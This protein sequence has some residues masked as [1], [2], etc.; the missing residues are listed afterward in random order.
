MAD[1]G[2]RLSRKRLHGGPLRTAINSSTYGN[3]VDVLKTKAHEDIESLEK[4]T[5]RLWQACGNF[6]ADKQ[7]D[8]PRSSAGAKHGA[9]LEAQ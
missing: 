6:W 5:Q 4:G 2:E 9:P 7:A 1:P 3:V 8:I